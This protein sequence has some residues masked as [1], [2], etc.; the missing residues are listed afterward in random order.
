ME[1]SCWIIIIIVSSG[2]L[3]GITNFLMLFDTV[4]KSKERW[5]KFFASIT[6]SL[7]ASFT[8]PL[9]LQILSNNILD[10][11]NFKNALIFTGFCIIASFFSKRFL[12]DLY[13][14]VKNLESKVE[15][16][17]EETK[18][19]LQES[20]KN[21]EAINKKVEDLEENFEESELDSIPSEVRIAILSNNKFSFTND[22]LENLMKSLFSAKYSNRTVIGIAK[23]TGITQEKIQ[24]VLEHLKDYGF[25][26]SRIGSNNRDFWRILKNPIKIY[27]AIYGIAGN[28]SDVT[29]KIKELISKGYFEIIA[30]QSFL[31]IQDPVPGVAKIMK[32]HCRIHGREKELQYNEGDKFRIE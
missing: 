20:A 13:Q 10:T 2:I 8:V 26:E 6:L 18:K 17:D 30:S 9:F 32:I 3:G 16:Q 7:C 21:T 24:Q 11:L 14:K 15:K 12:E 27:S 29:S 22:D 5:T 19:G 23:E 1:N 28:F 31:G 25:A 4:L